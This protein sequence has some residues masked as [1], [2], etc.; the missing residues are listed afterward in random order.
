MQA[1]TAKVNQEQEPAK[2]QM[3]MQTVRKVWHHRCPDLLP[4]PSNPVQSP[5]LTLTGRIYTRAPTLS[6]AGL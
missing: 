2:P 3:T 4:Y 6:A 5:P 1:S